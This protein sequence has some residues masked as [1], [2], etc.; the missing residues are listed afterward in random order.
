MDFIFDLMG[1]FH[2]LIVHLPIGFLLLG[3]MMLVFDRKENKHQKII[4]FTFFWG[5]FSTLAAIFTGTVQYNMEGYPW[6][7]IQGHLILGVLTFVFSF[8]IYLKLKGYAFFQRI[9]YRFLGYALVVILTI[10]GH[11][12]GNLTHGKDHLTEP[13]PDEIKEALGLEVP[14]RTP[15][16]LPE[17]HQELPL[18]SGVIQ[19]ILD[20]KCV[21]C[22][23]PNKTKGELLLHNYTGI[24]N[25]GEQGLIISTVHPGESEMIKRIHLP[26]EEKKH[27]PPKAKIQL[28]KAEINL[29]VKWINLG[30]PENSS[31]SELGLSPRLFTSFFPKDETGIYPDPLLESLDRTLIDSLVSKGLQVAPIYKNSSLL[32]ISAINS[33]HFDDQQS[34]VLLKALDHIVDLDIGHTQVTDS[35]FE[36]LKQLKNLTVLKL[37][38]TAITG[39]G[40]K[41]LSPLQYLKQI[42]LVHSNFKV[43]YLEN[44]YS[45]P[46]LEKVYLFGTHLNTSDVEIPKSFHS[47][48]EKGNYKLEKEV[49]GTL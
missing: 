9:S 26:L 11:L 24:M 31:I 1:R 25:G 22:H 45:F 5:T 41:K 2:P 21:S 15:V 33:P 47:I 46:A 14:S 23:N 13:L 39:N 42:N 12:G 48:F 17:T 35:V 37:N 28:S 27:M 40:I 44:L 34:I 8:L 19:P 3:L 38:R 20:Q 18:Y 32:K 49:D 6:E 29:I 7:D 30:A 10:T 16:L 36:I 4:R 43:D